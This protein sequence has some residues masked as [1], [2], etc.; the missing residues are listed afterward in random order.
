MSRRSRSRLYLT[1]VTLIVASLAGLTA[2][3]AAPAQ[4]QGMMR[5][6][7]MHG[8]MRDGGRR[9]GMDIGTGIGIG[10]G[11][12]IATEAIRRQRAIDEEREFKKGKAAKK[13][14]KKVTK[15]GGNDKSAKTDTKTDPKKPV[16][17][18]PVVDKPPVEKVVYTPPVFPKIDKLE[19]CD[20]CEKLWDSI[21]KYER[22]IAEDMKKLAE[23][24]QQVLDRMAERTKLT[25]AL[26]KA[27]ESYDRVY[28]ARMIEIDDESIAANTKLNAEL[29]E[30]INEEQA[31][32][33]ERIAAYE[34]CAEAYCRKHEMVQVPPVLPPP[35]VPPTTVSKPPQDPPQ[36]PRNPPLSTPP[37]DPD[38]KIC[39]PDI[40]D[41]VFDVLRRIRDEYTSHPDK[42]TEA[43]RTL[44]DKKTGPYA[45]D[46]GQLSPSVSPY[47]GMTYNP[48]TDQWETPPDPDNPGK[49]GPSMKPWFTHVSNMC[50]IPRPVC[51]ATVEFLGTCQHAQVVNYTQWGM[52]MS[53]CGGLYPTLGKVAHAAYNYDRYGATAPGQPQ[54]N[55]VD[56]GS[57]YKDALDKNSNMPDISEIR[58]KLLEQDAAT[59]HPEHDCELKCELTA[60]QRASLRSDEFRWHWTGL[61]DDGSADRTTRQDAAKDA[62][63]LNEQ[64]R[65]KA[66]AAGNEARDKVRNIGR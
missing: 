55:M 21:V 58:R 15:K 52:M 33:M 44:F 37:S 23:R 29:Q 65:D 47:G 50:A 36:E 62:K 51:G 6:D 63:K 59:Q 66:T 20:D 19:N 43:C 11:I 25:A 31:I 56:V 12:G 13:P 7:S 2:I 32:L 49:S 28:Y 18:K 1:K 3:G 4:G 39:G 40:T 8:G 24:Q 16:T 30:R 48:A 38:L 54:Q 9:G 5:E 14:E 26:A 17:D 60:A 57:G 64:A 27:T 61:T 45:W 46:I 10:V 41:R 53:L 34:K 22:I 35:T 42:Q